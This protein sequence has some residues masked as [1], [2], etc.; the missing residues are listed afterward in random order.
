[1]DSIGDEIRYG[2]YLD[3]RVA[4]QIVHNIIDEIVDA[5]AEKTRNS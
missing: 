5:Y 1:M 2:I 4:P 3:T